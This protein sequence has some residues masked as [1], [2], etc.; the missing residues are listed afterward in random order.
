MGFLNLEHE[1]EHVHKI[2]KALEKRGLRFDPTDDWEIHGQHP[3]MNYQVYVGTAYGDISNGS[4][5]MW[6]AIYPHAVYQI[7][8]SDKWNKTDSLR[9]IL[10]KHENR[11]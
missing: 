7:D 8:D 6:V 2:Q 5:E 11:Y 3:G 9:R 10:I 1:P 4:E